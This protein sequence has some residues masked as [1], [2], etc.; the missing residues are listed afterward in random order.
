MILILHDLGQ[1][2]PRC[3]ALCT[4]LAPITKTNTTQPVTMDLTRDFR[5]I[6]HSIYGWV[7]TLMKICLL[8]QTRHAIQVR[9]TISWKNTNN[10]IPTYH[11]RYTSICH[12]YDRMFLIWN[13]MKPM[14]LI[15]VNGIWRGLIE[16]I[17]KPLNLL[18]RRYHSWVFC[19]S[20][21]VPTYHCIPRFYMV[22]NSLPLSIP[23]VD[24]KHGKHLY[25]PGNRC[26]GGMY[27]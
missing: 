21:N 19:Y 11:W 12:I 14:T 13:I 22:F 24:N 3:T 17:N 23:F 8:N 20:M 25:C 16:T 4:K 15:G 6:V 5:V 18:P 1:N 26:V 9:L 2:H 7:N 27:V 10:S